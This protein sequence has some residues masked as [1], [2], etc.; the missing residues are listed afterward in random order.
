MPSPADV[1][2]QPLQMPDSLLQGRMNRQSPFASGLNAFMGQF[3]PG[4]QHA[5]Q[6]MMQK[7]QMNAIAQ[8]LQKMRQQ[9]QQQQQPMPGQMPG[10]SMSPMMNMGQNGMGMGQVQTQ[11]DRIRQLLGG[12][13]GGMGGGMGGGMQQNDPLGIFG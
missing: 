7:N 8:A 1:G 5:Q 9:G 10:P 2:F 11:A 6:G 4:M 12:G 13:P 3:G